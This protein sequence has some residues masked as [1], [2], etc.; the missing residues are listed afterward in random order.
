MTCCGELAYARV[1]K[2]G[3]RHFVHES[4]HGCKSKRETPQHLFIKSE[5][6]LGCHDAG[7]SVETEV[8]GNGWRADVLAT[9]DNERIALEIQWSRQTY[10]ETAA[11]QAQYADSGI[12]TTWIFRKIPYGLCPSAEL[13]VFAVDAD[14]LTSATI[15]GL[16]VRKFAHSLLSGH[17]RLCT[18]MRLEPIQPVEIVIAEARCWNCKRALHVFHQNPEQQQQLKTLHGWRF[19][20]TAGPIQYHPRV[21][22]ELRKFQ[23]TPDGAFLQLGAVKPR[24]SNT[25]RRTYLSQGCPHCDAIFGRHFL[26][27]EPDRWIDQRVAALTVQILLEKPMFVSGVH[28]C[29]SEVEDFCEGASI[30]RPRNAPP[31]S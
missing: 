23:H 25:L 27:F 14:D 31:R 6:A 4:G 10:E 24:F 16:S 15:E 19:A 13:P 26:D 21:L 1:S 17:F 29:Y 8:S 3:T 12:R 9:R 2:L 22:E 28:W 20:E 11:R 7:Y 5:L 18:H 30:P